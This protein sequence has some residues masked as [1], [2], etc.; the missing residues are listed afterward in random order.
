MLNTDTLDLIVEEMVFP[1]NQTLYAI[2]TV[3][4]EHLKNGLIR[5]VIAVAM[6]TTTFQY[7]GYLRIKL[8]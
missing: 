2:Y 5:D 7:G 6:A 4:I 8:I 3:T 1:G